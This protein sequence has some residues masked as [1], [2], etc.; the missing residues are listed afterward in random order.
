[1]ATIPDVWKALR[2][3]LITTLEGLLTPADIFIDNPP[4]DRVANLPAGKSDPFVSIFDS[5][6]MARDD[7]RTPPYGLTPTAV[8]PTLVSTLSD[9][10]LAFGQTIS[11]TLSQT[12]TPGDMVAIGL[13]TG[14]TIRN[15]YS[16]PATNASTP[17]T[18]AASLAQNINASDDLAGLISAVVNGPE[19]AITNISPQSLQAS[20]IVGNNG[21][22]IT[23]LGQQ[24]RPC[25]VVLWSRTKDQRDQLGSILLSHFYD[26]GNRGASIRQT[27]GTTTYI[28]PSGDV[29]GRDD[30]NANLYR[31]NYF[32]DAT[33]SI[34]TVDAL[35]SI[36]GFRLT[37]TLSYF[38]PE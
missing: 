34:T 10:F 26:M 32:L 12:P 18:M 19:L 1:M 7:S 22:Q 2:L 31:W 21:A 17:E 24:I 6:K 14:P 30:R 36:L 29:M 35:Y 15:G 4:P 27:D 11:L 37:K 20:T 33:I 5:P 38:L 9:T 3:D 13:S 28:K 16:A 23:V 8:T 25:M